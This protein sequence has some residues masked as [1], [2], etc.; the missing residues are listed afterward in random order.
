MKEDIEEDSMTSF[1][2]LLQTTLVLAIIV[3]NII[4]QMICISIK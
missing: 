1:K 3:K 2:V 4:S